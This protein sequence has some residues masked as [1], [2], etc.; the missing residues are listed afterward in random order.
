MT[1]L[2]YLSNILHHLYQLNTQMQ[3]RTL[4]DMYEKKIKNKTNLWQERIS[5]RQLS[6]F[7][8]LHLFYMILMTT[9]FFVYRLQYL[10][11]F[12]NEI[13]RDIPQNVHIEKYNWIRNPFEVDV[14]GVEIDVE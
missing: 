1:R 9:I 6:A 3:N 4:L 7:A 10:K 12:E 8:T 13:Q 2:A 5:N 14:T 11:E